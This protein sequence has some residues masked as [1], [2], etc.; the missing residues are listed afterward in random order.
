M[1][2]R[3]QIT[4]AD[5]I[6]RTTEKIGREG[7]TDKNCITA[8]RAA[9]DRD[10]LGIG[11]TLRNSPLDR[12]NQIVMHIAPPL[13]ITSIEKVFAVAS[14]ATKIYLQAGIATIR[15]PLCLGVISPPIT[16]PRPTMHVQHHWQ[17]FRVRSSG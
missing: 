10:S 3:H 13:V 1:N 9:I 12:I 6:D 14:R 2:K 16:R 15:K 4:G 7:G 17:V 5:N 11:G 8:I